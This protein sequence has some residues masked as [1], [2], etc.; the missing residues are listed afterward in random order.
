MDSFSSINLV[1]ITAIG[2]T[3]K[4]NCDFKFDA[5][6]ENILGWPGL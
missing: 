1:L 6:F 4:R 3:K 2:I 5:I